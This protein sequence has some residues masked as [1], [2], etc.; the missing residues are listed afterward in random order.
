MDCHRGRDYLDR[1]RGSKDGENG[2]YMKNMVPGN[3]I[4]RF[5]LSHC[6]E[7]THLVV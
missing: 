4:A 1:H 2:P 6:Y 7:V 3:F 5:S